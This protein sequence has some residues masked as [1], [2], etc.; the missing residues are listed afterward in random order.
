MSYKDW[1]VPEFAQ[2]FQGVRLQQGGDA[3][4]AAIIKGSPR[5]EVLF[6]RL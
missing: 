4:F 6:V 3:K 2:S 5:P 1:S